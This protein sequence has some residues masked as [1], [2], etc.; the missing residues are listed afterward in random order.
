MRPKTRRTLYIVAI[1]IVL[2]LITVFIIFWTDIIKPPPPPPPP[3]NDF[4]EKVVYNIDSLKGIPES[5]FC[6]EL[7]KEI[8]Y[9][10]DDY[11]KQMHFGDNSSENDIW[12]ENLLRDLNSAYTNKFIKQSFYV[13]NSANWKKDDLQILRSELDKLKKSDFIKDGPAKDKL[14]EIDRVLA[15]YDE[16]AKFINIYSYYS[17]NTIN[18]NG[19]FPDLTD[20]INETNNYIN[21]DLDNHYVN[22]CAYLKAGLKEIPNKLFYAHVKYLENLI[23]KFGPNYEDER[24]SEQREYTESVYVFLEKQLNSLVYTPYGIS[25]EVYYIEYKRLDDILEKYGDNAYYYFKYK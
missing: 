21:N 24:Y 19:S 15:K 17:Y 25:Y 6:V 22:N 11:S 16:I 4:T 12:K 18:L 7:Y 23:N 10:I 8:L 3:P 2:A 5:Q 13:F 1:A 14:N 9:Y 20:K